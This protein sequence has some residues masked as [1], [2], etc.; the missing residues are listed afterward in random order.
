MPFDR[1]SPHAAALHG[2]LNLLNENRLPIWAI[3]SR[4]IVLVAFESF[5]LGP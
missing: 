3:H 2:P 1:R 5:Q 4:R